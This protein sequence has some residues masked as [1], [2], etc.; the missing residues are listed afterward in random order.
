MKT[1]RNLHD[2]ISEQG[3]SEVA[4]AT[5][6]SQRHLVDLRCG[7]RPM[8][9]HHFQ[10]IMAAYPK[11]DGGGLWA[12]AVFLSRDHGHVPRAPRSSALAYL[13]ARGLIS[14]EEITQVVVEAIPAEP[15]HE[16]LRFLADVLG[17]VRGFTMISGCK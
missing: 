10:A 5:G 6:I 13:H 9:P 15:T 14:D 16:E 1:I 17:S 12:S 7:V 3:I 2:L 4:A 11:I 8:H